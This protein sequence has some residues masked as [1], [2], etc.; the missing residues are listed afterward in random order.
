MNGGEFPG[1]IEAR[2]LIGIAPVGLDAIGS[3]LGDEGGGHNVADHA[4][5]AQVAAE[6]EAARP[7]FVNQAQLDVGGREFFEEFIDGVEG[8]TDDAE[9][10]DS[11]E[12]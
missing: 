12:F 6:D 9:T 7:G 11:V 10:A 1:P 5:V 8:A 4:L 3:F 2:Q